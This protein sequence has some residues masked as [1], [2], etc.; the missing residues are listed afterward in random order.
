MKTSKRGRQMSKPEVTNG[1]GKK[2]ILEE[3]AVHM[4]ENT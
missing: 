2:H 4:Q 1:A 3:E